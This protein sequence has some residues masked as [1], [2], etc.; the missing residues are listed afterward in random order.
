MQHHIVRKKVLT[1]A[2]SMD[3]H[4]INL[5]CLHSNVKKMLLMGQY[6]FFVCIKDHNHHGDAPSANDIHMFFTG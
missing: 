4:N 6:I 5:I 3:K 1:Y 2:I